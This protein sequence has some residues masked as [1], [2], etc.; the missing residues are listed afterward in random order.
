MVFDR[1]S[2]HSA[3]KPLD[4]DV[5]VDTKGQRV[6]VRFNNGPAT[7]T[8]GDLLAAL[9]ANAAFDERFSAGFSNCAAG[10]A[11][12]PL[13][14]LSVRNQSVTAS[15]TG[16]TQ[17]AIEVNFN[18]FVDAV[19]NDELL[20]DIL[21]AAAVRTR[22]NA[23]ETLTAG[24]TRIRTAPTAGAADGGLSI[25]ADLSADTQALPDITAG[26]DTA[27]VRKVRY[28]META[29]VKNLPMVRDLVETAAGHQGAATA[30]GAANPVIPAVTAVATGYAADTDT[31]ATDTVSGSDNAFDKV[32]ENFNGKSQVRIAVS[33]SVKAPS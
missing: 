21:T 3:A 25:F 32:D 24:I 22:P 16:R 9:K 26:T 31:G 33:S 12:T 4:I 8:L 17:F 7:A 27:P 23:S 15:G 2:T 5:R 13:G 14:L 1:A 18:A 30:Q 6:T 29:L 10:V 19:S 28:E 20:T 11:T